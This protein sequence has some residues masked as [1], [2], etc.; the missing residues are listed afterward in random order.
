MMAGPCDPPV[1]D[2]LQTEKVETLTQM[3]FTLM[4]NLSLFKILT[5]FIQTHFELNRVKRGRRLNRP[6]EVQ[7]L[8]T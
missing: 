7:V 3:S 1:V 5:T 2:F 8:Q 6:A 4:L